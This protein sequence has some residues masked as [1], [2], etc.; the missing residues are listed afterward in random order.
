MVFFSVC[1]VGW[2]LSCKTI[3]IT[4]K[5]SL[6]GSNIIVL[7]YIT[8]VFEEL[9]ELDTQFVIYMISILYI[10]S[11]TNITNAG[12]RVHT[13]SFFDRVLLV[14]LWDREVYDLLVCCAAYLS[15]LA[16]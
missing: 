14:C 5:A 9:L 11:K 8:Q 10:L 2:F 6:G 13:V 12:S 3:Q 1:L 15:L 7:S 4:R 16:E